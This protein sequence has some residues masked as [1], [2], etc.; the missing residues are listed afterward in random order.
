MGDQRPG[1][2]TRR[3]GGGSLL[4]DHNRRG[5]SLKITLDTLLGYHPRRQ[6]E[7]LAAP[8]LGPPPS[9]EVVTTMNAVV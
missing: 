7:P 1:D 8:P 9:G 2:H 3:R 4:G 5:G 6:L